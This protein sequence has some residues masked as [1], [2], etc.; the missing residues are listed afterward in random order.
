MRWPSFR[1]TP[2]STPPWSNFVD[3][4]LPVGKSQARATSPKTT[5]GTGRTSLL[6]AWKPNGRANGCTQTSRPRQRQRVAEAPSSCHLRIRIRQDACASGRPTVHG[7]G[8]SG[9][10]ISAGKQHLQRE[11]NINIHKWL[12]ARFSAQASRQVLH[13]P[14]SQTS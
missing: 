2:S 4:E 10:T 3:Y 8:C 14:R 6:N 1:V 7:H 5:G 9:K 12:L 13:L 11:N